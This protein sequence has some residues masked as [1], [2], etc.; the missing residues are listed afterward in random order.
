[1][2]FDLEITKVSTCNFIDL[3]NISSI[4]YNTTDETIL[5]AIYDKKTSFIKSLSNKGT[6]NTKKFLNFK[7][8]PKNLFDSYIIDQELKIHSIKNNK[9]FL[10]P[11]FYGGQINFSNSDFVWSSLYIKSK[12]SYDNTLKRLSL[13]IKD[14]FITNSISVYTLSLQYPGLITKERTYSFTE[15]NTSLENTFLSSTEDYQF[16]IRNN[17]VILNTDYIEIDNKIIGV[18]NG[19]TRMFPLPEFPCKEI[20]VYG[21][22]S[23]EYEIVNGL[24]IFKTGSVPNLNEDI[25]IR[26]TADPIVC[27]KKS[28]DTRDDIVFIKNTISPNNL[29]FSNGVI[30][31]YNSYQNQEQP[32]SIILESESINVDSNIYRLTAKVTNPI[33]MPL[34]NKNIRINILE[35]GALF[36]NNNSDTIVCKTSMTGEAST[37]VYGDFSKLGFYVQKEWVSGNTITLPKDIDIDNL[38]NVFLYL[39][40]NDDPILG[41]AYAYSSDKSI[42]EYYKKDDITSY[43]VTGRKIAYLELINK[44]GKLTQKYKKPNN[45]EKLT[46]QNILFRNLKIGSVNTTSLI[47]GINSIKPTSL[48]YVTIPPS[49]MYKPNILPQNKLQIYQKTF[50]TVTKFTFD[51]NIPKTDAINGYLL[52]FNNT[53]DIKASYT[54]DNV[55]ITSNTEQVSIKNIKS[56]LPFMIS[57]ISMQ[58]RSTALNDLSYMTVSDYIMNDYNLLPNTYGCIY[59]DIID[60]KCINS[61]KAFRSNYKVDNKNLMCIHTPDYDNTIS[62]IQRCT[63]KDCQ[64]LNPFILLAKTGD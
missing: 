3:K 55:T 16:T 13:T 52:I 28:T 62:E 7:E 25:S 26:Y 11:I 59:S 51:T 42:E 63:G 61:N 44:D 54:D 46:N 14:K 8:I 35:D 50:P 32:S 38:N 40:M 47:V 64:V 6:I 23:S 33:G 30:C 29:G 39:V 49:G 19:A 2:R 9:S 56:E 1:M 34:K 36:S 48:A 21:Y 18:G 12:C 37:I 10:Y 58:D 53:V 4:L 57:G 15:Y 31:M 60:K 22:N 27:Y 17:K 45:I 20:E 24:L 41:K 5:P 43:Y